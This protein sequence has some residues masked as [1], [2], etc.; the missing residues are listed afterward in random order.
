M[1]TQNGTDLATLTAT[2]QRFHFLSFEVYIKEFIFEK[3][4]LF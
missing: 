1:E 4:F 2:S 3:T